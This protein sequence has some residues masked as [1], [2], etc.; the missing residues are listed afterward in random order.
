VTQLFDEAGKPVL[1]GKEIGRGGEGSVFESHHLSADS[2]AKVYHGPLPPEKQSKLR[3]MARLGNGYLHQISAWPTQ[4]LLRQAGGAVAG[5]VMAKIEG[6]QPIH[7][8]SSPASRKQIF[9]DADYAFVVH[10]ARN[11]AA[12]FDAVHA[13]GHVVGDVNENNFLVGRNGT[14]KLID[15]DSFQ[16]ADGSNRYLC[17]VGV[18][19]FTP[20][21]LQGL[22]TFRGKERTANHDNFGLAVLVFQLLVLGRHPFAGVPL[23]KGDLS[24]EDSITHFR[25]AYA[26]DRR[27]RQID[28]P[29]DALTLS[30]FPPEIGRAFE[31]AFTEQGSKV[32]RPTAKEWVSMLENLR[33]SLRACG[34]AQN[35]KY[36]SHL[37][38]CPWCEMES[39]GRPP[40]ISQ[41]VHRSSTRTHTG[42]DV[43]S[44][45]AQ[46]QTVAALPALAPY[47]R[48]PSAAVGR[49]TASTKAAISK[50][51]LAV[52]AIVTVAFFLTLA[53]PPLWILSLC[54]G[55]FLLTV[56]RHPE[57]KKI[58]Q[59]VKAVATTKAA[60]DT[61]LATYQKLTQDPRMA[62]QLR[63]LQGTKNAIDALP[64]RQQKLMQDLHA[65]LR[66]KQ[67]AAFLDRFLITEGEI[68]GIG[69]ARISAL[70]SFGI[71]T[72]KDL[73]YNAIIRVQGF[74]DGLAG[75]LLAW[76]SRLEG[77]F[78]FDPSKGVPQ[79]DVNAVNAK[80]ASERTQRERDLRD[81]LTQLQQLHA[82]ALTVR[83]S[84]RLR[85]DAASGLLD[86]AEADLALS[87]S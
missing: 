28:S 20:P 1:L 31:R 39:R 74:G 35:H 18:R 67:L 55:G 73:E 36:P 4:V 38:Q 8:L 33:A 9:P 40:F 56:L 23:S 26:S 15:C 76:R 13:H 59:L 79:Q 57:G 24:I 17:D 19:L 6:Y 45:W 41:L 2:V 7:N 43:A 58:G 47:V 11:V 52:T 46:I 80:I 66:D 71:E 81:G 16:I 60:F 34:Q 5:F 14:V 82:S 12:S 22:R 3:A 78:R 77:R 48:P 30:F 72:A 69:P 75:R 65:T 83:Q 27:Q 29:P 49:A 85:L 44:I 32:A 25:F 87:K 68:D 21:E 84:A 70:A 37:S 62:D 63:K 54:V 86:Q 64:A 10:V 53:A 51:R 61:E 50:Y 42:G